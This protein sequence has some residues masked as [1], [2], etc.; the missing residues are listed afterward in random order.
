MI[1]VG[2]HGSIEEILSKFKEFKAIVDNLSGKKIKFLRTDNGKEY[3]SDIFID[4]CK[5]VGIKR[6]FFLHYNPQKNG[7][8]KRKNRS[9]VHSTKAMLHDQGLET[10]LWGEASNIVV[11][12]Q[13]RC[14]H[15]YLEFKTP[16]EVFTGK[17]PDLKHLRIFGCPIYVHIPKEK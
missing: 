6:E 15:S 9:I 12:L 1:S 5:I 13:N 17:K 16:E 7:I 2:R 11:Y 4:Y 3:I 8:A 14:P 10:F